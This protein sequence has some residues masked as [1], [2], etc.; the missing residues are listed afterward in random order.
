VKTSKGDRIG[1]LFADGRAVDEALRLAVRDA[2]RKHKRH[3]VPLAIWRDGRVVW[4]PAEELLAQRRAKTARK[5]K[6]ATKRGR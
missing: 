5:E 6:P 3:N 4:V 1:R 2:I